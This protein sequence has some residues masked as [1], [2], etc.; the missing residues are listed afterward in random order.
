MKKINLNKKNMS[1]VFGPLEADILKYLWKNE[2]ARSKTLFKKLKTKHKY[3]HST[4]AVTLDRLYKKGI[5]KRKQETCR[6]GKRYIYYPKFS[7]EELGTELADKFLIFL[8]N[9]F[10][11]SCV[12]KF[13]T[14]LE[15]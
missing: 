4:I 15:E 11:E 10:G 13:K 3:T 7:K 14:K 12:A 5:V 8:R 1:S 2:K 9:T 6:G